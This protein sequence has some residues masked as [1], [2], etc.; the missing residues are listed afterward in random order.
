[1]TP[2]EVNRQTWNKVAQLYQDKFMDLRL[3]DV[4]YDTFIACLPQ[5]EASVLDVGCGPGNITQYLLQK[6]PDWV[7]EGIDAAPNMVA[8]AA[9]NL[10][11]AT[12]SVL[13]CC[14]LDRLEM[15]YH[16]VVCGFCLPYLEPA[17]GE[18]LLYDI[19]Q[20]LIPG[21]CLYLSFVPGDPAKSGYLTGSTGD[22]TYFHYYDPD[23]VKQRLHE[24]GFSELQDIRIHY[25]EELGGPAEHVVLIGRKGE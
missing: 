25:P 23:N 21:G 22:R 9:K 7:L 16:G 2:G 17:A 6:R 12:F 10:P 15:Q 19:H 13:D 14:A 4:S 3:Y 11:G 20:H 5:K 1:M 8:L 18:K 24:V